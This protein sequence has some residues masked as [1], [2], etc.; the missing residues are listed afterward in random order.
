MTTVNTQCYE[1]CFQNLTTSSNEHILREIYR[2]GNEL[3]IIKDIN[4]ATNVAFLLDSTIATECFSSSSSSSSS[5]SM[6]DFIHGENSTGI[7]QLQLQMMSILTVMMGSVRV[8]PIQFNENGA[9]YC[10]SYSCLDCCTTIKLINQGTYLTPLQTNTS[11]CL[12]GN[13]EAACRAGYNNL[14]GGSTCNVRSQNMTVALLNSDAFMMIDKRGRFSPCES[15]F[16]YRYAIGFHRA[17]H[18]DLV[19]FQF[20]KHNH[21]YMSDSSKV[22]FTVNQLFNCLNSNC[23][24][25]ATSTVSASANCNI[26]YGPLGQSQTTLSGINPTVA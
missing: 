18:R 24:A 4:N 9:W 5:E 17:E 3:K 14:M 11:A 1:Q 7:W 2:M 16:F 20:R 15:L 25:S 19:K 8:S 21:N 23:C 6:E 12:P 13:I 10:G 22:Q 26:Y